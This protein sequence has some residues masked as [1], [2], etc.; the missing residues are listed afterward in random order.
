MKVF[1]RLVDPAVARRII[2]RE[3]SRV[4]KV[5]RRGIGEAQGYIAREN[6]FS[7]RDIPPF[8]RSEVD[9]YAVYHR[10]V[11]GADEDSPVTLNITGEVKVGMKPNMEIKEGDAAYISTGAMIPR[12]ADSVVMV[13]DTKREGDKVSVYRSA[14]PGENIAHAGSDFFTGEVL[15]PEGSIIS[16]ETIALLASAGIQNVSVAAKLKAGIFSTGNEVVPPS[17][18]LGEGMIYDS[19]SYLF[20]ATLESTGLV[21]GHILGIIPDSE[22]EMLEKI[23]SYIRRYNVIFSSGS[24]SAGFHDLLY[25]VVEKLGGN[26]L[27]HGIAMKPGKPTFFASFRDSVFFGMPGFPLS[28]AS[29]LRYIIIPSILGAY[30]INERNERYV[31]IPF[32]M[33]TERGKTTVIP[34]IIGRKGAA[35]PIYGES[36]SISRLYYADG[37]IVLGSRKTFYDSGEKVKFFEMRRG[38][39]ELL[40]IGSNDPLIERV[41][42]DSSRNPKIINSGSWGGLEAMDMGEADVAGIH[43]L[44]DGMYNRFVLERKEERDYYLVRGFSRTQGIISREGIDSF[45]EI[46]RRNLL[47]VNRNKGSGT[48]DLIDFEIRKELGEDFEM[49]NIRGYLWEAKSHAAVAHAVSQGRADV[50][51]SIKFYAEKLGL[52][53]HKIRDEEYDVLVSKEFMNTETGKRFIHSLKGAGKYGSEFPGYRI[54]PECGE[55]IG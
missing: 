17:S 1:H 52:K 49:E 35:Y 29:V 36:G 40:F 12:G 37:F 48:R 39:K 15:C 11:E 46:V 5:E 3:A 43:L 21:E 14:R 32:R 55:I 41:I 53:F 7:E 2:K 25:R 18:E 19:N 33:N 38:R 20:K 4:I 34:A 51:V 10:S 27:F 47:F 44:K 42:Y 22:D 30:G 23:S 24:T 9:G 28:S 6:I 45:K 54:P 50:G 8:D 31:K 16:P 13:E 26:I